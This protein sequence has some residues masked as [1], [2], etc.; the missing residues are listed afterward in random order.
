MV[1][2]TSAPT[3]LTFVQNWQN[4]LI[5]FIFTHKRESVYPSKSVSKYRIAASDGRLNVMS[6]C[7][8]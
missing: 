7:R 8:R 2:A 4:R 1:E 5:T 6:R 3:I